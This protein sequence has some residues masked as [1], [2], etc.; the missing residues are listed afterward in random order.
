MNKSLTMKTIAIIP[1]RYASTRLPGK[2]LLA[3]TGKPLIQHVVEAVARANTIQRI[4]V[5]TDDDRILQAVNAFGGTAIMT[6]PAHRCG[7]DRIAEA[8][9]LLNL[10]DDDVVVNVQGDEPQ[11]PPECIDRLARIMRTADA[12]MATLATALDAAQAADPNKVKVILNSKGLAMY[13]SRACIPCDRDAAGGVNYLL[14]IGIYAY[15]VRFLKTFAA[16]PPTPAESA[17]KLEQLRALENGYPLA[18]AIVD[19]H[20]H[21]I[22][23]PD[24]YAAFLAA[25]G[26]R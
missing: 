17:E 11:L 3:A 24:D 4:V 5:A 23:T 21:G 13:F 12:L 26:K 10:A 25:C 6:S 15:R 18:V 2:M 7:T 22:D 1:A 8:A 16:L 19:Y 14:H 9:G 20:G